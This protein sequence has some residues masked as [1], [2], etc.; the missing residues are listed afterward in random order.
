MSTLSIDVRRAALD[1]AAEIAAVHDDV[2]RYAYRGILNG[3]D[4]ERMIERRGP[5][6]WTRAISRNVLI[7]VVEV[8]CHVVGYA[9]LGPSRLADLPFGGE[10]YELYV[11]PG[12]HGLGLGRRLFEAARELLAELDFDGLAV[13]VLKANDMAMR[14]YGRRGG[15][16]VVESGERIGQTLLPVVVFGWPADAL[17]NAPS[18]G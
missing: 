1:D 3:V 5:R 4:L 10:I 2:W 7:L 9:T 15:R 14:F 12:F 8:D 16:P 11:S 13:R 18:K 17:R 6:W